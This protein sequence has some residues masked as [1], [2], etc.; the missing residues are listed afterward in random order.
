MTSEQKIPPL[1][2]AIGQIRLKEQEARIT[3]NQFGEHLKDSG[4]HERSS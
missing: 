2:E 1:R 4:A 3:E